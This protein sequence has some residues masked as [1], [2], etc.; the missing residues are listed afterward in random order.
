MRLAESGP[1]GGTSVAGAGILPKVHQP[2]KP[3]SYQSTFKTTSYNPSNALPSN[4]YHHHSNPAAVASLPQITANQAGHHA[5][6]S[7][8]YLTG[9]TQQAW[10][11]RQHKPAKVGDEITLTFI[12]NIV[13]KVGYLGR[14]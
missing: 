5:N 6:H 14:Y 10:S 9:L 11:T 1:P 8:T 3:S 4:K 12:P 2:N 13:G 7:N